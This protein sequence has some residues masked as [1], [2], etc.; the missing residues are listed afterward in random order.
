M[1]TRFWGFVQD[2]ALSAIP[3]ISATYLSQSTISHIPPRDLRDWEPAFYSFLPMSFFFAGAVI[4]RIL[5][6]IRA[7]RETIAQLRS[8]QE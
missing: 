6:E 1:K 3:Y 2:I 5:R 7:L 4:F 8:S